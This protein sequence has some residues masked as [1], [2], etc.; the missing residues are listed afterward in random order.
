[1]LIYREDLIAVLKATLHLKC[2]E[3]AELAGNLLQHL[4]KALTLIYAMDYRSSAK[5][6]DTPLEEQLPIRV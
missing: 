2:R 4:L 3:G 1:L 6:W 5:G